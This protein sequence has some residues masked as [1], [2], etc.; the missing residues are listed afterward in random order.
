M[1][2]IAIAIAIATVGVF[3]WMVSDEDKKSNIVK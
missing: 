3:Y 1:E 2:L